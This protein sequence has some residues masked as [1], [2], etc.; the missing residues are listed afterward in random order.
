MF[1]MIG[2][3]GYCLMRM[4]LVNIQTLEAIVDSDDG[5]SWD[6]N[7]DTLRLWKKILILIYQTKKKEPFSGHYHFRM[8][9]FG[10]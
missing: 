7:R 9:L 10:D 2:M 6:S 8:S 3:S 1:S 5:R 4:D